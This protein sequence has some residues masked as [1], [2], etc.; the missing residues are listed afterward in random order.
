M[1]RSREN[2]PVKK[3]A[4]FL[5]MVSSLTPGLTTGQ[6]SEDQIERFFRAGQEAMKQGQYARAA[7][8]FKKVLGIDPNLVEPEVNVGLAYQSLFEYDQAVRHLAKALREKPNLVGPTGI[9]GMDYLKL[10]SP[11]RA[12]PYLQQ[13]LKLVPSN[14]D[15][16]QALASSYL[17]QEDFRSAA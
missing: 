5:L 11:E 10:G 14:R 15:A 7:E 3:A 2:V 12:I 9:V 6:T 17:G 1:L 4:L 8:D 16:A 13:A